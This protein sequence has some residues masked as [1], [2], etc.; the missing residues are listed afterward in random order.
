MVARDR[1]IAGVIA[2]QL[3]PAVGAVEQHEGGEMGQIN[4]FVEDQRRFHA[5]V[6]EE[7][8]AAALRQIVLYFV[9]DISV[10]C[11]GALVG[12]A[13]RALVWRNWCRIV[14]RLPRRLVVRMNVGL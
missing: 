6:G 7:N 3:L 8:A 10:I 2:L 12:L 14:S 1:E 13:R 5:A 9:I 11:T 4:P